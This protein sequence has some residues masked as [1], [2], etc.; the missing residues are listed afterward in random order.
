M[1]KITSNLITTVMGCMLF[2]FGMLAF[3]FDKL[4]GEML[5]PVVM[6]GAGLIAYKN[7]AIMGM[8]PKKKS[9]NE[10]A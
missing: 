7:A 8:L 5:I 10:D 2:L 4:S 6:A 3:W 1:K 9:T